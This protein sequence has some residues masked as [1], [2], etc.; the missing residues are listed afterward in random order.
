LVVV[1]PVAIASR[2]L[3]VTRCQGVHPLGA[4]KYNSAI[5]TRK[6]RAAMSGLI[7][8]YSNSSFQK[9]AGCHRVC[10]ARKRTWLGTARS[11][12]GCAQRT[13]HANIPREKFQWTARGTFHCWL[14]PNSIEEGFAT[15]W[16]KKGVKRAW[17][18]P[19]RVPIKIGHFGKC[20]TNRSDETSSQLRMTIPRL[21]KLRTRNPYHK[22]NLAVPGPRASVKS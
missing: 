11:V 3:P 21:N 20:R 5:K 4:K 18:N 19:K 6:T 8:L 2:T 15:T 17:Q 14:H 22:P 1:C 12:Q 16:V 9:E 13:T 10:Q 7:M